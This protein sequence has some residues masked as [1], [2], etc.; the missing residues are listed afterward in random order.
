VY[1]DRV[2][3]YPTPRR[4]ITHFQALRWLSAY[5]VTYPFAFCCL[6]IAKLLVLDRMRDFAVHRT[7]GAP[8]WWV[9]GSR[10]LVAA[11]VGLNF[12]GACGSVGAS[13]YSERAAGLY[14]AAA[15]AAVANSTDARSQRTQANDLVQNAARFVAVELGCELVVL[16]LVVI[17]FSV[18]G[19]ASF[20]RLSYVMNSIRN[21]D[22][23]G[24][25][26]RQVQ[27][28]GQELQRQIVGTVAVVFVSFLMR[29]AFSIMFAL[30]NGLQNSGDTC[31]KYSGR[32]DP[33]CYNMFSN[34][35]IW[36]LY[37]PE[38]QLLIVLISQPVALIIALWGM[39]SGRM[40]AL[41]K[42]TRVSLQDSS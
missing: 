30:A 1:N 24:P 5:L 17:A 34:M 4:R 29:V 8:Q 25:M 38:C 26:S 37:T 13:V 36:L 42:T 3:A 12:V 20:R 6:V 28:T 19:V 16:L 9:V 33:N 31:P 21:S 7:I 2:L 27:R 39:T 41:M 22:N 23:D 32:C 40:L 14:S 15:D 10:I 11:A 35:Q 18:V